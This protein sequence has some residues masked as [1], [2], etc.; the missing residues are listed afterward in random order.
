MTQLYSS[1]NFGLGIAPEVTQQLGNRPLPETLA[2]GDQGKLVGGH[3][4]FQIGIDHG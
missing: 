4:I 1:L 3:I 2:G